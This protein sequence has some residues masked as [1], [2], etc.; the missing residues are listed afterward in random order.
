MNQEELKIK[1]SDK[2]EGSFRN[3]NEKDATIWN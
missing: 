1:D 2:I 3:S